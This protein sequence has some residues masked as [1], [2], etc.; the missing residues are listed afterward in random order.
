MKKS[1]CA[2]AFL[3]L[4][5]AAFAGTGSREDPVTTVEDLVSALERTEGQEIAVYI[6]PGAYDVSSCHMF[7]NNGGNPTTESVSHIALN[8]QTLS[9]TT[10]NPR[11][12]V[13]YGNKT[14]RIVYCWCGMVKN[15]TISNGYISAT[16]KYSGGA[17]LCGRNAVTQ[18]NNIIV[19]DC[20]SAISGGGVT[21][22][23]CTNV[24]VENCT[25]AAS[26]GGVYAPWDNPI[27]RDGFIRG[28]SAKD[29][30]GA[31]GVSLTNTVVS[32][33]A[34]AQYGGG[35]ANCSQ[36]IDCTIYDNSAVQG[37]G[38]YNSPVTDGVVSNNTASNGGGLRLGSATN[39]RIVCNTA[40]RYGGG[41]HTTNVSGGLVAGNKAQE[42]SGGGCAYGTAI[43]GA[44]ISNNVAMVHGGGV[45]GCPVYDSTICFNLLENMSSTTS[46][47]GGVS[48]CSCVSNCLVF[49][50]AISEMANYS[51]SGGAGRGSTFYD[52]RVYNNFATLGA[53]A[54]QCSFYGCLISNNVASARYKH[55]TL[56]NTRCL[57]GCDICGELIDTPGFV[58]NTKFHGMRPSWTL[59]PGENIF[60]SGTFEANNSYMIYNTQGSN[61]CFTNCLFYDNIA[62]SSII[63]ASG[64]NVEMPIV[65]CTFAGNRT[66][67]TLVGFD[68]THPCYVAN[69]IFAD[70]TLY[71]GTTRCAFRYT[72][73]DSIVLENCLVDTS[74][75]ADVEALAVHTDTIVSDAV[76]F[77]SS[78]A[79]DPYSIKATSR[80][81]GRGQVM[82]WMESAT[83]IRR[84]PAFPRLRDGG[85]D[86]GCYQCWLPIPG[87]AVIVK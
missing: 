43:V 16:A 48:E 20:Q 76:R 7:H 1:A 6:A 39:V 30:A 73:G 56:R 2:L 3:A 57:V 51:G 17:G 38:V 23:K 83:D 21:S 28:C 87:L 4:G 14:D 9:G 68:M 60:T 10:D 26:G 64:G 71:D 81:R 8:K 45:C 22:V 50:N 84:D 66:A 37:G 72:N 11:D 19:T 44:T 27:F 75:Q 82:D 80:A 49:G 12:V 18:A 70:N 78:N 55:Y 65:N 47:G 46:Q 40:S 54:E 35:V 53:A 79:S 36:V 42:G 31:Y 63:I 77:D 52:C 5:S 74:S 58:A 15:L 67:Y 61:S 33:N 62:S 59:A 24:T 25:A 69:C 85:V 13:L 34:S 86:I 41:T 32:G 29:G